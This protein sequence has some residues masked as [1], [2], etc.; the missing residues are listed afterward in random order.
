MRASGS[1]DLIRT[2]AVK[3]RAAELY[4]ATCRLDDAHHC[5]DECALSAAIRPLELH[6]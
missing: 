6:E 1:D 2:L 5:L 4:C 3:K